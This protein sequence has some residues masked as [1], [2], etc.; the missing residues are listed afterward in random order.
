MSAKINVLS[1][2]SGHIG[3]LKNASTGKIDKLDCVTF[4]AAPVFVAF[5]F[6]AFGIKLTNDANSLLVNFG[7]IFT[8]LLL[9][10]LVLV[11]DQSE[12]LQLDT[13]QRKK[14]SIRIKTTLIE[15]LC[16]NICY[17]IVLSVFLVF[18]C[19]VYTFLPDDSILFEIKGYAINLDFKLWLASPVILVVVMNLLL[20]ILMVVKRMH[21]L[22]TTR[23][24][25]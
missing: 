25:V 5:A 11:Y 24:G 8:T 23:V 16:F 19:L 13:D 12:K 6:I 4:F 20:T 21:V 10:V 3:T 18:C 22:L 9:S 7:A 1:I 17:S 14:H 2:L 15:Q